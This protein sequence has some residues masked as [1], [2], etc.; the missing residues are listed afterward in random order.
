MNR[1]RKWPALS[2]R[3]MTLNRLARWTVLGDIAER[4]HG[5]VNSGQPY[6]KHDDDNAARDML[7][8]MKG[9]P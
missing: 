7:R 2:E 5:F 3:Y 6:P 8:L 4:G 9:C 1:Q